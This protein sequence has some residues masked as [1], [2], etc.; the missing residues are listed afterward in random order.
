[1]ARSTIRLREKESEPKRHYPGET[2]GNYLA[3]RLNDLSRAPSKRQPLLESL[4]VLQNLAKAISARDRATIDELQKGKKGLRLAYGYLIK[5]AQSP[6]IRGKWWIAK[7]HEDGLIVPPATPEGKVA[8]TV[9]V[10][11]KKG[12]IDRMRRC[13]HCRAWFYARFKHQQFCSNPE[14]EC[15]W[16]HYHTPEW[17]REHREKNKEH[18]T[19]YRQRNPGRRILI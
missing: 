9:L 16:N 2:Q 10:L 15:Q 11:E 4:R 7:V 5:T 19:K 6:A 8:L 18:Q 17:R 1:V 12:R 3:G 14:Q 13:I